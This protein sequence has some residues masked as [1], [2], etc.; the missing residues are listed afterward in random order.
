MRRGGKAGAGV[1]CPFDTA[2]DRVKFPGSKILLIGMKMTTRNLV[3]IPLVTASWGVKLPDV[4]RYL[5]REFVNRFFDEGELMIPTVRKFHKHADEERGDEHEGMAR[6][7]ATVNGAPVNGL[8]GAGGD[9]FILSTSCIDDEGLMRQLNY[10][11]AIRIVDVIGFASAI[12]SRIP[13]FRQG[14]QGYCI[15]RNSKKVVASV[16]RPGV[17]L[18]FDTIGKD[19]IK[20]FNDMKQIVSEVA[21]QDAL[22]RKSIKYAHQA[23]YRFA[24]HS[25]SAIGQDS[26]VVKCP[27]ARRFCERVDVFPTDNEMS[28]NVM[29]A[30][31][32]MITKSEF[33]KFK[34]EE[35]KNK[36]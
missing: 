9:A 35:D 22:F 11:A 19:P 1:A 28:M 15:Y 29:G 31:M 21:T 4:V 18:D 6:I 8:V 5:E 33:E 25:E 10:D 16:S 17:S 36:S 2:N 20:T 32:S 12:A 13:Y 14:I 30:T 23:E 7:E 24:W 26:I 34:R 27:D 3:Q